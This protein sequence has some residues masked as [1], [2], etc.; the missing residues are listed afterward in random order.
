MENSRALS[1]SLVQIIPYFSNFENMLELIFLACAL[2]LEKLRSNLQCSRII[3][4][5]LLV[6]GKQPNCQIV[7]VR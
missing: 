6:E 2:L 3:R 4:I 1:I 7:I 5:S